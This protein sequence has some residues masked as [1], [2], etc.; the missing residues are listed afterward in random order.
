MQILHSD[1][2]RYKG[3]ISNNHRVAN[4]AGFSF[5]FF[6]S[7][8]YFLN[9]SFKSQVYYFTLFREKVINIVYRNAEIKKYKQ[10]LSREKQYLIVYSDQ[11][12]Q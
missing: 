2:L 3:T 8:K 1:W 12:S 10:K 6:P 4:F 7:N 11:S 9:S 5:L